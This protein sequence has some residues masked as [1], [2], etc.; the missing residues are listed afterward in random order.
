MEKRED[1]RVNML[2]RSQ[3]VRMSAERQL[4]VHARVSCTHASAH[5]FCMLPKI[6]LG[7]GLK[8]TSIYVLY[9]STYID[10]AHLYPRRLQ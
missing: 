9:D 7:P 10:I 2:G 3:I 4:I 8:L 6:L 1:V 5:M